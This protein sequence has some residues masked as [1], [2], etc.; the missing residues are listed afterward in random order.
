MDCYKFDYKEADFKNIFK[1]KGIQQ[2]VNPHTYWPREVIWLFIVYLYNRFISTNV[3][4][5]D[6]L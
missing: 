3:K 1:M 6:L 4:S 2:Q 5:N